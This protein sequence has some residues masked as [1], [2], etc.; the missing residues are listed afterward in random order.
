MSLSPGCR[1]TPGDGCLPCLGLAI[2]PVCGIDQ[3][4][5]PHDV[6][7]L[8]SPLHSPTSSHLLP[9][10]PPISLAR[11]LGLLELSSDLILSFLM[12]KAKW[13][14]QSVIYFSLSTSG[15]RPVPQRKPCLLLTLR[16]ERKLSHRLP[17]RDP[18]KAVDLVLN[19]P[20]E[21]LQ[22]VL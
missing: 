14:T 13:E 10:P 1:C 17:V 19:T 16:V 2:S 18:V 9:A 7:L 21:V 20:T 15:N 22:Q 11:L 3:E 4:F 6:M 5:W 8:S 12:V